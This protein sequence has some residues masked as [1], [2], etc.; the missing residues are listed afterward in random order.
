[1]RIVRRKWF[2]RFVS[3]LRKT[4][5][6]N[7]FARVS[8]QFFNDFFLHIFT[9]YTHLRKLRSMTNNANLFSS[10]FAKLNFFLRKSSY[11]IVCKQRRIQGSGLYANRKMQYMKN[12]QEQVNTLLLFHVIALCDMQKCV[13]HAKGIASCR[14]LAKSQRNVSA[15]VMVKVSILIR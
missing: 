3:V 1:M 10:Y 2:V 9:Y 8:K 6:W 7:A 4:F 13:L 11:V 5:L 15:I 14:W 12:L